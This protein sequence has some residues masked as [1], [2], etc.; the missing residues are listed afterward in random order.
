MPFLKWIFEYTNRWWIPKSGFCKLS[1]GLPEFEA[2]L[3]NAETTNHS[4]GGTVHMIHASSHPMLRSRVGFAAWQVQVVGLKRGQMRA[5][6]TQIVPSEARS[7]MEAQVPSSVPS[8]P[9][10]TSFVTQS[11]R[12]W[13][14]KTTNTAEAKPAGLH[15]WIK[16][17]I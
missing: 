5:R 2:I 17:Y 3:V 4:S 13:T 9:S 16:F 1:N 7:N 15:V 10:T 14:P 6:G 8:I 12:Y 11:W